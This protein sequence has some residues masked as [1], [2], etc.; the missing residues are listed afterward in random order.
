MSVCWQKAA[1]FVLHAV[2]FWDFSF[3]SL[4][5]SWIRNR[6]IV[7]HVWDG[8]KRVKALKDSQCLSTL[9]EVNDCSLKDTYKGLLG[10]NEVNDIFDRS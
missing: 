10:V 5:I 3:M 7:Q 6:V 1:W 2:T 9:V 8:A 4:F